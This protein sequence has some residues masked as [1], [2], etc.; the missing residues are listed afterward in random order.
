MAPNSMESLKAANLLLEED[1]RALKLANKSLEDEVQDLKARVQALEKQ[2]AKLRPS[3]PISDLPPELHNMICIETFRLPHYI[4]DRH[5]REVFND[6]GDNTIMHLPHDERLTLLPYFLAANTFELHT[7]HG[8]LDACVGPDWQ[9]H[10]RHGFLPVR[11]GAGRRRRPRSP[12]PHSHWWCDYL[13]QYPSLET[14][15]LKISVSSSAECL[16]PH[17]EVFGNRLRE[18]LPKMKKLRL[19]SVRLEFGS[20]IPETPTHLEQFEGFFMA[21]ITES[22]MDIRLE[23]K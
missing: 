18:I 19:I 21:Q 17:L 15:N 12:S 6:P 16:S 20:L 2:A 13:I 7:N 22:G 1:N 23:L 4:K 11:I 14:L 8:P 3:I 10:V 9:K 5:L